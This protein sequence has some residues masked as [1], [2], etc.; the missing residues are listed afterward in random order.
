[1]TISDHDARLERAILILLHH[2]YPASITRAELHRLLAD[3]H[4]NGDAV[5]QAIDD[6]CSL[7]VIDKNPT[8]HTLRMPLPIITVTTL[9]DS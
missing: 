1:M 8:D 3:S 6:L 9:M 7:G 5:E 4:T 2:F